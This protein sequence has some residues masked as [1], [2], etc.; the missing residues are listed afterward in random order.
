[1]GLDNVDHAGERW[2]LAHGD[3]EWNA[4]CAECL[5]DRC[6]VASVVDIFRIH[7]GDHDESA[8]A[9]AAGF[10]KDAPGVDLDAGRARDCDDDVFDRRECTQRATDEIGVARRIDQVDLFAGPGEVP[11]V[12][13]DGEMPAFLFFVDVKRARAVVD[14]TLAIDRPGREKKGVGQ[15]GFARRPMSSQGN[16]A[17]ISDMICR[18]HSVSSPI[19]VVI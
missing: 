10:L 15:C 2:T 12:A 3:V 6:Q 16:V 11:E 5:P 14:R 4:E 7:L 13:I 8:E 18:G 1:M 9:E 19:R 17:D